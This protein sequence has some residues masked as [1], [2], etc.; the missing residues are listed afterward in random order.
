[1][2]SDRL[3]NSVR[4]WL[5]SLLIVTI[6]C[7]C[8]FVR[9]GYDQSETLLRW[10][11]NR[12]LDLTAEQS[13]WLKEELSKFHTWH[14]HTQL[15]AY[16]ALAANLSRQSAEEISPAQACDNIDAA[17][18]QIEA[19]LRQAAPVLA[20]LARQLEMGQL[21]HL[22]RRFAE[23]DR[24]WREKWLDAAPEKRLRQRQEDWIDRAESYYGR[25]TREQREFIRQ[26]VQ[27]S[28]WD[29]QLS[30]ERRQLRQQQILATLD[31]IIRQRLPQQAAE[32][33]LLALMERSLRPEDSRFTAMQQLLQKEACVNLAGLH[34]LASPSQR[35]KARDKL[36][37]YE[38][39]FRQLSA[40]P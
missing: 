4:R 23:D 27:R 31:K 40:K 13:R 14:R 16:A 11:L 1:M 2:F 12:Q 6:L 20:G 3:I 22:R 24:E 28:S 8:S 25:L 38:Q 9:L 17:A 7:G 18:A 21:Q 26:A 35:H 36:A 5:G 33:E 30:W 19:L 34:Q 10:W 37:A 39:D 29:S 15:P 32:E